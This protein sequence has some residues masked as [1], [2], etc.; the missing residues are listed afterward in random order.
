MKFT[1]ATIAALFVVTA[2]AKPHWRKPYIG[3]CRAAKTDDVD[4]IKGHMFFLQRKNKTDDPEKALYGSGRWNAN[5]PA[6]ADY[7]VAAYGAS[8][9]CSEAGTDVGSFS[10]D[11]DDTTKDRWAKTELT[12]YSLKADTDVTDIADTYFGLYDSA[13]ATK[14]NLFCCQVKTWRKP[15]DGARRLDG[16]M[17]DEEAKWMEDEKAKWMEE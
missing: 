6:S 5:L 2:D 11:G 15:T 9:D 10:K 17:S 16:H 12:G 4:A 3:K 1:I 8:A 14:A 13:D 7:T